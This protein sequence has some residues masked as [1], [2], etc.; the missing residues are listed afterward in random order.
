MYLIV[1]ESLNMSI[2]KTAAQ[3][4]HA[5]QMLHLKYEHEHQA[6]LCGNF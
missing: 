6:W 1:R 2:G 3:V 4:G 5:V